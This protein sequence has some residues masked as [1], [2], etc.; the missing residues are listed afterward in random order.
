MPP[1]ES[2][3][4]DLK[5]LDS[6]MHGIYPHN[7]LLIYLFAEII[8][9]IYRKDDQPR[10]KIVNALKKTEKRPKFQN[11][12]CHKCGLPK[13]NYFSVSS[14]VLVPSEI[15]PRYFT[16]GTPTYIAIETAFIMSTVI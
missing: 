13:V 14:N 7:H 5:A 4:F 9:V 11:L 10:I 8:E 12:Y 6:L 15:R 1:A 16:P 2:N 3:P